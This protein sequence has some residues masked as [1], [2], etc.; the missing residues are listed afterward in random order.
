[1]QL[2]A[3]AIS[4]WLIGSSLLVFV[5]QLVLSP[6][7]RSASHLPWVSVAFGCMLLS[8]VLVTRGLSCGPL[9][10]PRWPDLFLIALLPCVLSS[11]LVSPAPALSASLASAWAAALLAGL[12]MRRF[13]AEGAGLGLLML[14]V[15]VPA[16]DALRQ[17]WGLS[18]LPVAE[19][20][21]RADD[22]VLALRLVLLVPLLLLLA[23]ARG[24]RPWR[25]RATGPLLAAVGLPLGWVVFHDLESRAVVLIGIALCLLMLPVS[26]R[27]AGWMLV[28]FLLGIV[29]TVLVGAAESQTAGLAEGSAAA[30]RL[31]IYE[32]ALELIGR[33]PLL[34]HGLGSFLLL[35]PALRAPG[36]RTIGNLVHNDYLQLWLE[37][38]VLFLV[39]L[40]LLAAACL[41]HWL[42]LA[43]AFARDA[44]DEAAHERWA[45]LLVAAAILVHALVNFPL[46]DPATL[47]ILIAAAALGVRESPRRSG[48]GEESMQPSSIGSGRSLMGA[49][50]LLLVP[51]WLYSLLTA[52][53]FVVLLRVPA[54]PFLP[55]PAVSASFQYEWAGHLRD[56][57]VGGDM[58]AAGLALLT[59]EA[60]RRAPEDA[61]A[62]LPRS[63]LD[64]YRE[65]LRDAPF[66]MDHYFQTARLMQE[67]GLGDRAERIEVLEAG[68]ERNPYAASLWWTLAWEL[69]QAGRWE[70]ES[71]ERREQW[72]P[73][74]EDMLR[75]EP[76]EL[77]NFLALLPPAE[78]EQ[79]R[80]RAPGCAR[81]LEDAAA[82]AEELRTPGR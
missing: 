48:D 41:V 43:R 72:L 33:A 23:R 55:P 27:R 52:S 66:V 59:A 25:T 61:P 34:G 49:A 53:A 58:P 57:G 11:V 64:L 31:Q 54:L 51:A 18:S 65:A 32:A 5:A 68:L 63:A 3:R 42:R 76:R 2:S 10:A 35:Y 77:R 56:L 39:W 14:L 67:S 15:L 8:L 26:G 46:Y 38:G 82:P 1:M 21:A 47:L 20:A 44:D 22:N 24:S 60:W 40:L 70:E 62:S 37:G 79:V 78:R 6:V 30:G 50:L 36:D 9:R 17:G 74:C 81:W 45:A 7:Q 80:K 19:Q 71:A 29:A 4:P 13:M 16:L 12:V 73:R 75:S 28:G 69:T